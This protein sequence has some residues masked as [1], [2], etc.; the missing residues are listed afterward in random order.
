M[1]LLRKAANSATRDAEGSIESSSPVS[2]PPSD[3]VSRVAASVSGRASRI[4][5]AAP[6][7]G[8]LRKSLALVSG[9]EIGALRADLPAG[10][11]RIREAA[12]ETPRP[13]EAVQKA[14]EQQD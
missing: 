2:A 5:G 13:P 6:R 12:A 3:R 9:R 10:E 11:S 1:G 4:T 7:A 8:L 14:R